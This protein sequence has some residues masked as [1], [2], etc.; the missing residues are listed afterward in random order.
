MLT[1]K[2]VASRQATVARREA[3]TAIGAAILAVGLYLLATDFGIDFDAAAALATVH[4]FLGA[5]APLF[6]LA[7]LFLHWVVT[8]L[9][10]E[11]TGLTEIRRR[12]RSIEA[13]LFY[14]ETAAPFVGL[15]ECFLSIVKALLAYAAAGVSVTAQSVLIANIAVAL[16]ASASG[17]FVALFAH[18][19][20]ALLTHRIDVP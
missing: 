7:A 3:D 8:A 9:I 18:S 14:L 17:C 13:A 16:G 12:W 19:L 15:L 6:A 4:K 10:L 11:I 20:K 5:S 1:S 2:V